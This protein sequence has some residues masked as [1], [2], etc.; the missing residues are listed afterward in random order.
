MKK[1]SHLLQFDFLSPLF[2]PEPTR[3]GSQSEIVFPPESPAPPRLPPIEDL[4]ELATRL[5]HSVGATALAEQMIL[6]WN[7]RLRNTA[8]MAYPGRKL[9]TLNPRLAQFGPEEI[10][11]TL[12]HELAH[13]LAHHR[14]GRRRIDPHGKEWKLACRDLGL[15]DEKRTHDLP[16]PRHTQQPRHFYRCPGCGLELKRVKPLRKQSACAVCC[17]AHSRGRFDVRFRFVRVPPPAEDAAH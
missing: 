15:V 3:A 14:A 9:I 1:P 11:R 12:R 2:T 10:D 7:P 16:L 17:R 6:R 13:L 4:H 5:L 8:G